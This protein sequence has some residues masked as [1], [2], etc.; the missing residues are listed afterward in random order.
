[1][2]A[3]ICI[4]RVRRRVSTGEPEMLSEMQRRASGG[5]QRIETASPSQITNYQKFKIANISEL[6]IAQ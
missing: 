6:L 2:P 1:M 3:A 4:R 5:G